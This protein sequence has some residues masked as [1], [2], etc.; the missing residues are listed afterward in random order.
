M[1]VTSP[2]LLIF[3]AHFYSYSRIN[4]SFESCES[5]YITV[6]GHG[7]EVGKQEA[8]PYGVKVS[9]TRRTSLVSR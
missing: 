8:G 3:T 7:L 2:N 9:L 1:L 6:G 4:I 5:Y